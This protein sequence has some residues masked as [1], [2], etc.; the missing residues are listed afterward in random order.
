MVREVLGPHGVAWGVSVR[1]WDVG[2]AAGSEETAFLL[3]CTP[4]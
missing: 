2:S 1:M 4:D 3:A